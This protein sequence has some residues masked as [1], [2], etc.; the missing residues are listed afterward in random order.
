[1]VASIQT[2]HMHAGEDLERLLL[3]RRDY[4]SIRTQKP[5]L[6]GDPLHALGLVIP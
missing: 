3:R 6:H 4:L 1:M 2:L 5:E